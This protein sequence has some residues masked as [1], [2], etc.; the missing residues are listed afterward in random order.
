MKNSAKS[1]KWSSKAKVLAIELQRELS[2]NNK[3]WHI[4]KKDSERRAAELISSSIVQLLSG[5]KVI[6]IEALINQS[7]LWLKEEIKDPGCPD[8]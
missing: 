6:E 7:L 5:G 8:H 2:I 4:H 3:N 1:Y